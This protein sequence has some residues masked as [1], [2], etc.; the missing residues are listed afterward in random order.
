MKYKSLFVLFAAVLFLGCVSCNGTGEEDDTT[1]FTISFDCQGGSPVPDT[2]KIE[3]GNFAT[4]PAEQ[5]SLDGRVFVGWFTQNGLKFNFKST[6]VTKDFVLVA[7]YWDGPKKYIVINDYD[8]SYLEQAIYS[9]F[10]DSNGYDVAVGQGLLF[11]IFQRP[12]DTHKEALRKHLQLSEQYNVP[13]LVQLDPITF[14]DNVPELWNWF[15]TSISGY[16]DANR[17]NVEWTSWSSA[18]AVKLGWLNWGSQIRLRPMANLFSPAYQAAVKERMDAL[19]SIVANWYEGLPATKK[20]LLIGVKITGELGVGVNNWHYTGGNDLYGKSDSNDPRSGI[21]MNNKPS[22]SNGDV[23]TIGYAGCKYAGIKSSGEITGNDIAELEHKFT[24][25]VSEVAMKHGIPREKVFAHAGGVG[26]DLDACINDLV[27]PS[28][29]FYGADASDGKNATYCLNLFKN[30]SA[31]C[32]GVAEWAISASAS[33]DTW[34][35]SIRKS[36]SIDRC[37]FLSI[38]TNVIGNNNGTTVNTNA[39]QG[40]LQIQQHD[41]Y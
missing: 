7:H 29:S 10:G 8:W 38:Y 13:V 24:L 6:P 16:N 14:W 15:D 20:H 28:W 40:I 32:W 39:V 23:S 25:F 22:R 12:L 35:S 21:N 26:N 33:A 2:Q 37:Y 41:K 19:I 1:Y 18:D 31:P 11:Y 17:E 30:S 4:E 34:A 36:L 27:C 9:H 5:P 3:K